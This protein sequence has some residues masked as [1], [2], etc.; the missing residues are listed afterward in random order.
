MSKSEE[1]PG[2][3]KRLDEAVVLQRTVQQLR[4][5]LR[6]EGLREPAV[7][8]GAFEELRAQVEDLLAQKQRE[9]PHALGLV[10]NRV[11]LTEGQLRTALARGGMHG[12]AGAVV[13]RCLQKVLSRMRFAGLG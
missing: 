5:D 10:V 9:G 11:D 2:L 8:E 12:V 6:N 3:R 13:L 7:G 1:G 4:K